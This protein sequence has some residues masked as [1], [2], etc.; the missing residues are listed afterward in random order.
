MAKQKKEVLVNQAKDET[1]KNGKIALCRFPSG[2]EFTIKNKSFM[3]NGTNTMYPDNSGSINFNINLADY[4]QT[5]ITDEQAEYIETHYKHFI[6]R[7]VIIIVDSEKEVSRAKKE[8]LQALPITG[9]EQ[10]DIKQE[11]K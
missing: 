10:A 2:L 9:F 1:V 11:A 4:G 6:E 7:K 3:L 8:G 5:K